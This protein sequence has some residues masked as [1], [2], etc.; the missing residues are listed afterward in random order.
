M[1]LHYTKLHS[2][3]KRKRGTMG[4][5]ISI[6][7]M[8]PNREEITFARV[9]QFSSVCTKKISYFDIM[10]IYKYQPDFKWERNLIHSFPRFFSLLFLLSRKRLHIEMLYNSSNIHLCQPLI[11]TNVLSSNSFKSG[12]AHN[13]T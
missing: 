5:A 1:R 7:Y 3:L 13:N 10:I 11:N 8:I 9:R 2:I 6:A 12:I 4:S